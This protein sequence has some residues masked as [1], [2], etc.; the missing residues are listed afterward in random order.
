MS[1]TLKTMKTAF[2][3]VPGIDAQFSGRIIK[4]AIGLVATGLFGLGCS[5]LSLLGAL[6]TGIFALVAEIERG[7][8]VF[9]LVLA[10]SL[11]VASFTTFLSS[12]FVLFAT[13]RMKS[14]KSF[15]LAVTAAIV[16]VLPG[17]SPFFPLG[18]PLGIYTLMVLFDPTVRRH[19]SGQ[20][21]ET[22]GQA[23]LA[24]A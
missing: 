10:A 7:T 19:F 4:P 17:L 24:I 11:L 1:S 8:M 23:S 9:S 2:H 21:N 5:L 18:L 16:A 12:A 14:G 20:S 3:P 22:A 15:G 13:F 6:G